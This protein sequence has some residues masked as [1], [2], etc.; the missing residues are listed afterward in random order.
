MKYHN[1][2]K[3]QGRKRVISEWQFFFAVLN[4]RLNIFTSPQRLHINLYLGLSTVLALSALSFLSLQESPLFVYRS[5]RASK[6][7]P[8]RP[9]TRPFDYFC[10][11]LAVILQFCLS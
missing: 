7:W 4:K 5:F 10:T 6:M 8:G 11:G 9:T 2:L 3:N 1:N